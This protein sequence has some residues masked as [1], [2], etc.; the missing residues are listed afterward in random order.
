MADRFRCFPQ[1]YLLTMFHVYTD[2]CIVAPNRAT[3]TIG[4]YMHSCVELACLKT[5][6]S[7]IWSP[8][9]IAGLVGSVAFAKSFRVA[10]AAE[11]VIH[12]SGIQ[13]NEPF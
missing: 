8:P 1:S 11:S 5:R 4:M 7:G 13:R 10:Y 2:L 12:S 3:A 9:S 6:G